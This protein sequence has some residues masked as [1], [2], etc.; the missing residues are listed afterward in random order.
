MS[1]KF[2]NKKNVLKLGLSVILSYSAISSAQKIITYD[3]ADAN[4]AAHKFNFSVNSPVNKVNIQ[5]NTIRWESIEE[6]LN[7]ERPK[8]EGFY[9]KLVR[10]T[11]NNELYLKLK[12]QEIVGDPDVFYSTI[13]DKI[14]LML[15]KV[16]HVSR[17]IRNPKNKGVGGVFESNS[18]NQN[19]SPETNL[20]IYLML[21]ALSDS[22]FCNKIG[23]QIDSDILEAQAEQIGDVNFNENNELQLNNKPSVLP[24][25]KKNN[26]ICRINLEDITE[27]YIAI[28]HIHA[29][30]YNDSL[31]AGP[32]KVDVRSAIFEMYYLGKVHQFVITSLEKGK[33][34]MDYYGGDVFCGQDL[35]FKGHKLSKLKWLDLGVYSYDISKK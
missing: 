10:N 3:A 15:S 34:N 27:P 25:T 6:G 1:I 8:E 20:T 28:Y 23:E 29:T 32:S 16:E 13:T 24:R 9:N 35:D 2:I 11:I 33:F 7:A 22:S 18:V 31:F 12:S 21:N 14:N 30:Q 19:Y 17:K 5:K 4:S 26:G